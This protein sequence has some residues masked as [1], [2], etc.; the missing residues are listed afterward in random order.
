M[1]GHLLLIVLILDAHNKGVCPCI[2]LHATVLLT[3]RI[4]SYI[5]RDVS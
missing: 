4:L 3:Y 5:H 1:Y 2:T